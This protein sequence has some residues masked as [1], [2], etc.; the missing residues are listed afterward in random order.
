MD[1]PDDIPNGGVFSRYIAQN[2]YGRKNFRYNPLDETEVRVYRRRTR[3]VL[4]IELLAAL[5]ATLLHRNFLV[6]I[7]GFGLLTASFMLVVGAC[8]NLKQ[9]WK[10][11]V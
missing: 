10:R 4:G 6:T 2:L 8:A 7:I 1:I 11:C 9:H 5:L 3:I